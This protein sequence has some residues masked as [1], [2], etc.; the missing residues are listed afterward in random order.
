MI[1]SS[2]KSDSIQSADV[3]GISN[4]VL[5]LKTNTYKEENGKNNK[6]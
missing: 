4:T 2:L 1:P 6:I 3:S 5:K